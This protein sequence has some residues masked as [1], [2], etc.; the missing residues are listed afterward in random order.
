MYEAVGRIILDAEARNFVQNKLPLLRC[1]DVVVT[2][3]AV[4]N[5][6][7]HAVFFCVGNNPVQNLNRRG[8]V[9]VVGKLRN[10][11]NAAQI[12]LCAECCAEI[13]GFLHFAPLRFNHV[14]VL[15]Q[16][17]ACP[18][19]Y[20]A[21]FNAGF[22]NGLFNLVLVLD[23]LIQRTTEKFRRVQ[24]K[25][26]EVESEFFCVHQCFGFRCTDNTEFHCGSSSH[27]N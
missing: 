26:N 17:V 9:L 7:L 24:V 19:A 1:A 6:A 15:V 21:D 14:A 18:A 23:D 22:F 27:K 8:D 10:I 25:L 13:D 16:N 3:H 11:R 2:H 20:R 5:A 4:D 12:V